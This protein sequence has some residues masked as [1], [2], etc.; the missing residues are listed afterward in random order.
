MFLINGIAASCRVKMRVIWELGIELLENQ[1]LWFKLQ[2][3][4]IYLMM[5]I[6]GENMD[7]K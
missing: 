4:L 1:E 2:V 5:G 3:I 7:R 6:D